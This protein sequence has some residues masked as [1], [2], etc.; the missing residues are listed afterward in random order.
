M[1]LNDKIILIHAGLKFKVHP[2]LVWLDSQMLETITKTEFD[3]T[4]KTLDAIIVPQGWGKRG[5]EGKIKAA[6]FARE[7]N[8]PFLGLC[9]GMQMA[10]IEFARNVLNLKN[11]N[12]TEVNPYTRNSVIHIMPQQRKYLEKNQYGG[13]IRLGAWP[14][15]VK[16]GT[17]LE[18][19]YKKYGSNKSS[20]WY[21]PNPL[22]NHQS[23]ITN[24]KST[25][26][27]GIDTNL[28]TNTEI[29]LKIKV[30]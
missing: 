13:T 28:I 22:S 4:L 21:I 11:A 14:C 27:T 30:L 7:N 2:K 16:K 23:P 25:N 19:A 26:A 12:T 5:T 15:V 18:N 1:Y 8:I 17:I 24:Y 20:P 9:F 3:K 10:T 29:S 6:K